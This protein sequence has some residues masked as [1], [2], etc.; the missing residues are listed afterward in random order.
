MICHLLTTCWEVPTSSNM[1]SHYEELNCFT[2]FSIILILRWKYG[3]LTLSLRHT[4][5]WKYQTACRL[6]E[7]ISFKFRRNTEEFPKILLKIYFRWQF[8]CKFQSECYHENNTRMQRVSRT[9]GLIWLELNMS[10]V[11]HSTPRMTRSHASFRRSHAKY[12]YSEPWK[13]T[14]SLMLT[15]RWLISKDYLENVLLVMSTCLILYF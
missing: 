7:N 3:L 11:L 9:H 6:W 10:L 12:F 4:V 14:L 8:L 1:W 13:D 2:C 15:H 5:W